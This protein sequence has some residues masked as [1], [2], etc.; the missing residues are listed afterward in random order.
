MTLHV[1]P[2]EDDVIRSMQWYRRTF[3]ANLE[4]KK[5]EYRTPHW[6]IPRRNYCYS[7]FRCTCEL[8]RRILSWKKTR[9]IRFS[10]S[11]PVVSHIHVAFF[12]LVTIFLVSNQVKIFIFRV[13]DLRR[14]ELLL[15]SLLADWNISQFR[16]QTTIQVGILERRKLNEWIARKWIPCLPSPENSGSV[17]RH[18]SQ[19]Y[20]GIYPVVLKWYMTC[21]TRIEICC[22]VVSGSLWTILKVK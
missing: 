11:N 7:F 20:L 14:D 15:F 9:L 4:K 5:H 13:N 8:E 2:S 21:K 16:W 12:Y 6:N 19:D 1:A 18:P 3:P 10:E 17:P 22:L